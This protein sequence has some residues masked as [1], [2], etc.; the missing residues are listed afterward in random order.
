MQWICNQR[1]E[2]RSFEKFQK[3]IQLHNPDVTKLRYIHVAGTNG[4]GSTCNFLCDCLIEAGYKVGVFSSP[5]L[6]THQDR[7]CINHQW[8]PDEDL[9]RLVNERQALWEKYHLSM[10]EIDFDMMIL[11]FSRSH[12]DYVVLEV[13]LGGRLDATNVIENP[14]ASVIVSIGMD[15]MERLGNTLEEIA[16]EKAGIIKPNHLVISGETKGVT[17]QKI[18]QIAQQKKAVLC[19]IEFPQKTKDVP[20]QFVY[21]EREYKL[22]SLADYQI[23]NAACAIETLYQLREK[24]LVSISN[25]Q[26]QAGIERSQWAGRFDVVANEPMVI[27]DGAHNEHGTDALVGSINKLPHPCILVF[28]ALKDKEYSAMIAKLKA[29]VDEMIITQFDFYRAATATMLNTQSGLIVMEDWKQAIE[30]ACQKAGKQGSVVVTGSLYFI[31]E[32]VEF[33]QNKRK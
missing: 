23:H 2:N 24:G 33:Y 21:R 5:H 6:V 26:I 12:V 10:F 25:N 27:V 3:Y 13:G 18:Q 7:I 14:L 4:K 22:S 32:I 9:L 29:S 11:Y 15:H 8:I 19:W 17:S 20:V 1:G 31:S 30:L 28:A 16:T